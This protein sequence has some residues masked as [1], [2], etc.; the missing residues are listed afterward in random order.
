MARKDTKRPA[1]K[2]KAAAKGTNAG[3][4]RQAIAALKHENEELWSQLRSQ[5]E[6]IR[7]LEE[8]PAIK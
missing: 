8:T 1:V 4:V 6:R 3:Q 5:G 7:A 2:K